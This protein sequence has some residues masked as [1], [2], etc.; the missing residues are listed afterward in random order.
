[1]F[2]LGINKDIGRNWNLNAFGGLNGTRSSFMAGFGY[3]W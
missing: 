2:L 1:M 3:R